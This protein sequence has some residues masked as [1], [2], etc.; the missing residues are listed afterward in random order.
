MFPL[1]AKTVPP[2][3]AYCNLANSEI[4]YFEHF[5][6]V[7]AHE[8]AAQPLGVS[9]FWHRTVPRDALQNRFVL[10]AVVAISALSRAIKSRTIR[11][12]PDEYRSPQTLCIGPQALREYRNLVA[13]ETT[14]IAAPRKILVATLLITA[15]E[16]LQGNN[17]GVD[18]LTAKGILVLKDNIMRTNDHG[19]TSQVACSLD[20]LGVEEAEFYL[21]RRGAATSLMS[22]L[23][24]QSRQVVMRIQQFLDSAWSPPELSHSLRSFISIYMRFLTPALLWLNRV[25]E[26]IASGHPVETDPLLRLEQITIISRLKA[27]LEAVRDRLSTVSAPSCELADDY[28]EWLSLQILDI[29]IKTLYVCAA[30]VLDLSRKSLADH[31]WTQEIIHQ[32]RRMLSF[33]VSSPQFQ[34]HIRERIAFAIVNLSRECRE[35]QLRC[36]LLELGMKTADSWDMKAALLGYGALATVENRY[37]DANGFLPETMHHDWTSA[38]WDEG[39]TTLNVTITARTPAE[40]TQ[41][42]KRIALRVRDYG[43]GVPAAGNKPL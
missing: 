43:L 41:R 19:G 22:P 23:Y 20:D 36:E 32:S 24:P 13:K 29:G 35:P 16:T 31:E 39:H 11:H 3:P 34:H 38:S 33:K 5:Q 21:L 8:L 7:V 28:R 42:Q 1:A 4:P 9:E 2:Q 25:V 14:A 6:A 37:R 40:R 26:L 10:D 12:V 27:W 30:T 17:S 15:F 18:A